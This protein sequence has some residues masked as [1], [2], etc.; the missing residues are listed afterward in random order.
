MC[1]KKVDARGVGTVEWNPALEASG[2]WDGMLSAELG[3]TPGNYRLEP[4]GGPNGTSAT[5]PRKRPDVR[6]VIGSSSPSPV[7]APVPAPP[8]CL[9]RCPPPHP[10]RFS[11]RP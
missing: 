9:F 8:P 2:T 7:T 11:F 4:D 10:R 3:K 5:S 6:E 1:G